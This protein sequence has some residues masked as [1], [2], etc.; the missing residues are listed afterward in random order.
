MCPSPTT[1]MRIANA[2]SLESRK[3]FAPVLPATAAGSMPTSK[4]PAKTCASAASS[5]ETDW[6]TLRWIVPAI[7]LIGF[8]LWLADEANNMA[9]LGVAHG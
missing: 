8:V 6:R 3:S 1:C 4:K 9:G 7:L 2:K 5:W